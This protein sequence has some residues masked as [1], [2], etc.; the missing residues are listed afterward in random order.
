ML[1]VVVVVTVEEMLVEVWWLVVV[2][3]RKRFLTWFVGAS[4]ATRVVVVWL[5]LPEAPLEDGPELLLPGGEGVVKGGVV[6]K[7]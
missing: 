1:R 4:G 6:E 3:A 2:V 7:L 5:A